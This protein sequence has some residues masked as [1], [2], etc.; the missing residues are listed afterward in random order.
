MSEVFWKIT[1]RT[2]AGTAPRVLKMKKQTDGLFTAQD[3][4]RTATILTFGTGRLF[5]DFDGTKHDVLSVEETLWTPEDDSKHGMKHSVGKLDILLMPAGFIRAILRVLMY[6]AK[7]YG[8]DNWKM[9]P[10]EEYIKAIWR[11]WD[12]YMEGEIIDTDTNE[13]HLVCAACSCAFLFWL[14]LN[15]PAVIPTSWASHP[16]TGVGVANLSGLEARSVSDIQDI[17]D[18]KTRDLFKK[19]VSSMEDKAAKRSAKT[20]KATKTKKSRK[21]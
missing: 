15:T 4:D 6:G 2:S 10:R 18:A 16:I 20:K 3:G 12:A 5:T 8:R 11:H 14:D 17:E 9:V 1:L 13:H 21:R 7:K 19:T